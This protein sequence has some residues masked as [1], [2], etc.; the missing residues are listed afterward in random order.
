MTWPRGS[1]PFAVEETIE[2]GR[3]LELAVLAGEPVDHARA[4]DV[5]CTLEA[6]VASLP[7][8]EQRAVS[9]RL[10]AALGERRRFVATV[11]PRRAQGGSD[12]VAG[13]MAE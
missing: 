8:V 6:Y 3:A 13:G 2:A 5:L 7:D 12:G 1:V 10:V 9:L 4:H 11:A